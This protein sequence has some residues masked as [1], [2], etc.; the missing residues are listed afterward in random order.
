MKL[1]D[2]V[3]G[4][5]DMVPLDILDP[6]Y[7][8]GPEILEENLIFGNTEGVIQKLE[9]YKKVASTLLFVMCQ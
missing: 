2:A 5:P 8:V 3:N 7:H 6:S 1:G 4:Y 9:I